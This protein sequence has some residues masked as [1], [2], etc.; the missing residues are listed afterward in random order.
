MIANRPRRGV[1]LFAV[2]LTALMVPFA[3]GAGGVVSIGKG[4]EGSRVWNVSVVPDGRRRGICLQV[5]VSNRNG[6]A[7]GIADG[8]CAAPARTRGL[9]R[10]VAIRSKD[11]TPK[12]T[13]LGSAFNRAVASVEVMGLNGRSRTLA[14]HLGPAHHEQ[15]SRFKYASF[16]IGGPWCIGELVT[17][18]RSGAPLWTV[19]ANDILPYAPSRFCN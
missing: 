4:R 19:M 6:R 10:S 17:R 12:L 2:T 11:G 8:S 16:A 18:D 9:L 15:V 1:P 13:I 5:E 14:L 3:S 7:G